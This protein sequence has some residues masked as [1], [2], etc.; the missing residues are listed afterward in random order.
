MN[1]ASKYKCLKST[2]E[3]HQSHSMKSY[4]PRWHEASSYENANVKNT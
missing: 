2:L 4:S 1:I 3:K